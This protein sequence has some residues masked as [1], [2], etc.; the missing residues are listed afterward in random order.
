MTT[1]QLAAGAR[2]YRVRHAAYQ[3]AVLIVASSREEELVTF[4]GPG[5]LL[6]YLKAISTRSK[7]V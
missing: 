2:L 1:A 3:Q 6:V 4:K 7:A 5:S